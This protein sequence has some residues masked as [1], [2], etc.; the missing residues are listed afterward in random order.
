MILFCRL[1]LFVVV[2]SLC[3]WMIRTRGPEN[4]QLLRR[5]AVMHQS[6]GARFFGARS[7]QGRTCKVTYAARN[8]TGRQLIKFLGLW[9]CALIISFF[10]PSCR[11]IVGPCNY[12]NGAKCAG[13]LA[14]CENCVRSSIG[15][16]Q[17]CYLRLT[18]NFARVWLNKTII[19]RLQMCGCMHNIAYVFPSIRVGL[20]CWRSRR[21][22][23]TWTTSYRPLQRPRVLNEITQTT[24]RMM[25]N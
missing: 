8:L 21:I 19:R 17:K 11:Q 13:R 2:M 6:S 12:A 14:D 16:S 4:T 18:Q 24:L 23:N 9:V 3:W 5:K 1:F 20:R 22:C 15:K 10:Q 25:Q 7:Q